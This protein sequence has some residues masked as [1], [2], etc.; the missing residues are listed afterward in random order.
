MSEPTP[1][2]SD[3]TSAATTLRD[4]VKWLAAAF[5]GTAALV[6]GNSPLSALGQLPLAHQAL[7]ILLLAG[8]FGLICAAL[9][10]T[11]R[12]L[13]PDVLYRSDLLGTHDQQRTAE[14]LEE[15]QALRDTIDAHGA[16]LLPPNADSLPQLAA[17]LAQIEKDLDEAEAEQPPDPQAIE[18][19][20]S[21]RAAYWKEIAKVLPL[22]QYLRLHRRFE[23]EQLRMAVLS[24]LALLCLLLFAI[25]S[26]KAP[27]KDKPPTPHPITIHNSCPGSCGPQP[28]PPT[29][30]PA[31]PAVLFE[32]DKAKLTTSGQQAIQKARDEMELHPRA[33]LLVQAHTDTTGPLNHNTDL[34]Q[35]RA[36]AVLPLLSSPGGIAPNRLLVSYLPKT[37][38]PTVT[39]DQTPDAQNRSVR[40][41]MIEDTRR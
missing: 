13:K 8:G 10:R 12:I 3:F 30:F 19:L 37:A 28:P 39:P 21:A 23:K 2:K 40:L 27:D 16:D 22:A 7:A 36:L 15:L 4:T 24:V 11:L 38:L 1:S 20:K 34:A 6:I 29:A 18:E 25:A 9:W 5:A 31:L 41:V 17:D 35:R 14:E 32:H 26:S 33:L